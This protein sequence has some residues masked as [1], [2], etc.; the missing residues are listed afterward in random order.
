[1]AYPKYHGRSWFIRCAGIQKVRACSKNFVRLDSAGHKRGEWKMDSSGQ[2]LLQ[3]FDAQG[4][5]IWRTD[6][7][8]PQL[9]QR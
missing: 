1:M 7:A 4:R 2:A 5:V 3:L 9:L 8:G 6:Q